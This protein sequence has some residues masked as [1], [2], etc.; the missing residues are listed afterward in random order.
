MDTT[1]Q[2]EI[3]DRGRRERDRTEYPVG[4]PLLPKVPAGRYVDEGFAELERRVLLR[5]ELA[6]GGPRRR[7][8]RPRRSLLA[9][10]AA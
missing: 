7:G 1:L 9:R 5:P 10:A 4:F 3:L 2:S 6:A 8:A